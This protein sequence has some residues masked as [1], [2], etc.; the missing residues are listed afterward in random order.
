MRRGVK[1]SKH[2]V[3]SPLKF[4]QVIV[5][6]LLAG[7]LWWRSTLDHIQDQIG[8]LF[9]ISGFWGTFPV[10]QAIFTF[11][12]E[13]AMLTKERSSGMY[14]LSSYLMWRMVSDMPMLKNRRIPHV[15]KIKQ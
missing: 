12:Q 14:R 5:V 3:F 13:R 11:P 1:E 7:L 9:F 10:F 8:L 4:G 6:A 2:E 15:E